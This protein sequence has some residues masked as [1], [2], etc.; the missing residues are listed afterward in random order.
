[1]DM[2]VLESGFWFFFGA[3]CYRFFS[4]LLGNAYSILAAQTAVD[5]ILKLL[6]L[7][8]EAFKLIQELKYE[9]L[10]SIDHSQ[11]EIDKMKE[12]DEIILSTWQNLTI[13]NLIYSTPKFFRAAIKFSDWEEAKKYFNNRK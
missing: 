13:S 8:E 12:I 1:M 2:G 4:V 10:R 3:M 7:S 9:S 6:F 11:E 5:E